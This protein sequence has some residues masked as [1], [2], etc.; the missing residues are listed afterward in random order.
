MFRGEEL[1]KLDIFSTENLAVAYE[2][3]AE[4]DTLGSVNVKAD[5]VFN[6]R[7]RPNAKSPF[8]EEHDR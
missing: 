7:K 8:G 3:N 2:P 5:E 6:W 1:R 4:M